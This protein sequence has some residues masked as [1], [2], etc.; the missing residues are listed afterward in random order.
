M[1][2]IQKQKHNSKTSKLSRHLAQIKTNMHDVIAKFPMKITPYYASLIDWEDAHDP[3]KRMVIP[4]VNELT[5]KEV[6]T[7]TYEKENTKMFGLQHKYKQTAL[8][9]VSNTCASICRYCFRKRF[10]GIHNHEIVKNFPKIIIYLKQ[11][12]EITNV[13]LSGGDPLVLPNRSI[14]EILTLLEDV[15]TLKFIRIGSKVPVTHPHRIFKDPELLGI[16]KHFSRKNRRILIQTHFNHSREITP[17]STAAIAALSRANV[18]VHNQTVLLNGVNDDP[19]VL[20]D[21]Q[22]NLIQIGVHPYYVFQCRP[23]KKNVSEFQVS[24]SRGIQIV[25]DAKK[26]LSGPAKKFRYVMSHKT[27]KIE[28]LGK[29]DRQFLF[30]YHQAKNP[31]NYSRMFR[32]TLS[33]DA[34]WLWDGY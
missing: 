33:D 34:V 27:G 11:H 9:L 16:L 23:F 4:S 13:L 1:E 18:F 8:I 26:R 17:E 5:Y 21:L 19:Q 6:D 15:K 2:L 20:A 7:I 29:L 30:K 3:I 10:V 31:A 22:S 28:I 32:K 24:L 12:P 14:K 25:R